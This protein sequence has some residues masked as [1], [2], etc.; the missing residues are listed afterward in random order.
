MTAVV[1]NI[2]GQPVPKGRPRFTRGGFA[3]TPDKTRKYEKLVAGLAKTAMAGR[4]PFDCPVKVMVT[5]FMRIPQMSR[6]RTADALA[7]YILPAVK[8]DADNLA[9]AA[10]D[11]CNGIIWRD[12]ALICSLLVKKRYAA[13]PCLEIKV[14]P[15]G[16]CFVW[17][18]NYELGRKIVWEGKTRQAGKGS[19]KTTSA[20]DGWAA[21]GI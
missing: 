5:A 7:G 8:P 19:L 12:D 11:A 4:P 15:E 9:K 16:S 13:Y 1:V 2:P 18:V 21:F 14:A 20:D 3:Y 6:K 10:L 17:K